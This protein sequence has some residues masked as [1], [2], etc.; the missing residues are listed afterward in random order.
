VTFIPAVE[1]LY[2]L[3]LTVDD[4]I[5]SNMLTHEFEIV[6]TPDRFIGCVNGTV[7]DTRSN[8]LWLQDAGCSALNLD[9]VANQ[10]GFAAATGLERVNTLLASGGCGLS[11]GSAPGD[12]RLPTV[13]EFRQIVTTTPFAFGPPALLNGSG[14]GQWTEGDVFINVGVTN[15]PLRKLFV[16]WTADPAPDSLNWF[17]VNFAYDV[18]ENWSESQFAGTLNSLW[19]VRA[20]RPGEQCPAVP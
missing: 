19:P 18:P 7:L 9:T 10:W 13:N 12:W 15:N 2:I 20:L 4:G 8:L 3:T 14:T 5:A 11:D 16:Y 1:G 6:S 17:F